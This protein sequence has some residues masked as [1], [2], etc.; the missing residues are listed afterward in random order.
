MP[1][2]LKKVLVVDDDPALR[3][4]MGFILRGAAFQVVSAASGQEAL[5]LLAGTPDVDLVVT[6]LGM[7]GLSGYDVLERVLLHGGPPVMVVTASGR[8]EEQ[9][10]AMTLGAAGVLEKPFTRAGLLSAV[11]PLLER[12]WTDEPATTGTD[13]P[14]AL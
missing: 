6:D 2:L 5:D 8:P 12:R 1:G 7:P 13:L 10:H 3:H 14:Q 4:L 11:T 9:Q